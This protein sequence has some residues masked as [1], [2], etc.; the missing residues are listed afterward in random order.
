METVSLVGRVNSNL[1]LQLY[2]GYGIRSSL[3]L[4]KWTKVKNNQSKKYVTNA[5][6]GEVKAAGTQCPQQSNTK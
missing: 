5:D 4:S 6:K 2:F 3:P 1:M